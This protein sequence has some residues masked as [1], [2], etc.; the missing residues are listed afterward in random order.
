MKKCSKCKKEVIE[1]IIG[2]DLCKDC[3]VVELR[4]KVAKQLSQENTHQI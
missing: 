3:Y 1:L 4:K 2:T